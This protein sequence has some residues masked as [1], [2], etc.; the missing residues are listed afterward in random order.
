MK[1]L[2]YFSLITTFVIVSLL[3]LS[4]CAGAGSDTNDVVYLHVYNWADYIYQNDPENDYTEP[5]MVEQFETYVN[6]PEMKKNYG[7][8]KDVKVIYDTFDTPETMYNEL[9]LNKTSYDIM[10]PSDYMIQKLALN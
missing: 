6:T 8:T 5:D 9:K 3:S 2:K 10:C 1:N 7:L 4:S